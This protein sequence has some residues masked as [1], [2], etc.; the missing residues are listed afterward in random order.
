MGDV[1][2]TLAA[3]PTTGLDDTLDTVS[4]LTVVLLHDGMVL[5]DASDA[6][7][8]AYVNF[9]FVGKDGV[10]EYLQ[11]KTATKIATKT[12]ELTDL[13]RGRKGTDWSIGPCRRRGIR[14]ARRE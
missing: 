4:V 2:G 1:T 3:G 7:L 10:G 13:R 9:A 8:D 5:A 12:W 14:L 11:W 6:E